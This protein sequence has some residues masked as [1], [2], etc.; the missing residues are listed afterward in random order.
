MLKARVE[1]DLWDTKIMRGYENISL[2]GTGHSCQPWKLMAEDTFLKTAK[3]Q[4]RI[5]FSTHTKKMFKL[6]AG[7]MT[8]WLWSLVS[9]VQDLGSIYISRP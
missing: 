1:Y 6:G 5:Y 4:N 7:E 2:G 9:L 3:T 8:Q